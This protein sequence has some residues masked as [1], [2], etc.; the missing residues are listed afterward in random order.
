MNGEHDISFAHRFSKKMM[1]GSRFESSAACIIRAAGEQHASC[2][3]ISACSFGKKPESAAA[4]KVVITQDRDEITVEQGQGL[5]CGVD[6]DQLE[7][8]VDDMAS[9]LAVCFAVVDDKDFGAF[10]VNG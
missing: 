9:K 7:G 4:W 10:K 8:L 5:L 1:N 2:I 3:E 6:L